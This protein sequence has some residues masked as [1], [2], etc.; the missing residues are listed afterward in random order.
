M[1][2]NRTPREM[3]AKAPTTKIKKPAKKASVA[4]RFDNRKARLVKSK[5]I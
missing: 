3:M 4:K 1:F 5:T 2:K